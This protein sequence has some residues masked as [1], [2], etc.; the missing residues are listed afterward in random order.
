MRAAK[1][2]WEGRTRCRTRSSPAA[3]PWRRSRRSS[4]TAC[5]SFEKDPPKKLEDWPDDELK[6][7]TF[8]GPEGDHSY[9][10]GPERQLGPSSLQR[11]EDGSISIEGEKVEDPDAYKQEPLQGLD[12]DHQGERSEE[13]REAGGEQQDEE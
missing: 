5:P 4:E 9:E 1:R 11:H 8:G 2:R 6:Y 10:E 13:L 3:S 12:T 7:Q